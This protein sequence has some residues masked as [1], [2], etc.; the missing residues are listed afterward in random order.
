MILG[1]VRGGGGFLLQVLL[2][3]LGEVGDIDCR[4]LVLGMSQCRILAFLSL[5]NKNYVNSGDLGLTP[6]QLATLLRK[7]ILE[8]SVGKRLC[9]W[10][11][12]FFTKVLEDSSGREGF[13]GSKGVEEPRHSEKGSL[14][15][16]RYTLIP[17]S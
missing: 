5:L 10:K 2:S 8:Y 16:K 1:G 12:F 3:V 4:Y 6:L 11:P 15:K 9:N 13:G 14:A 7:K 17:L